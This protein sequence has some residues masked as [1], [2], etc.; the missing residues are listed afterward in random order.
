[1]A[2][3]VLIKRKVTPEKESDLLPLIMRLR[4]MAAQEPGYVSGETLR[5]A[6]DPNTYLVISTWHSIE[7]WNNWSSTKTRADIQKQ[8]D[9]LLGQETAY[10]IYHYP[11]KKRIS[12]S[13]FMGGD[14]D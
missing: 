9:D 14:S 8:I 5:K 6:D 1:M 10:E 7:D 13:D 4:L 12:L 11:E 2:V 3:R